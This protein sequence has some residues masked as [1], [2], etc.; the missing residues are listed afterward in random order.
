MAEPILMTALSPTMEDGTIVAWSKNEGDEISAGDVLCEV[1]TDKATMDYESTQDG[2]LLKI[3]LG[4]GSSA[5]V[6]DPIG[7]LG[8]AGEDVADLE[9]ELKAQAK[10]GGD[11][12]GSADS[13]EA[14]GS[15]AKDAP[16]AD[17]SATDTGSAGGDAASSAGS[18]R[19]DAAAQRGGARKAGGPTAGSS[20]LPESD[21]SIKASPLARKLA[22]S[23]NIDLRMIQGSG[24]GGRIVKADIESA[25]PA[26]LTPQAPAG[27]GAAAA[28]GAPVMA[29]REEPVAGKR[30]VIARRLSESKFSAPHYYLK[31]TAEMDSLIAARSMLNRELP[32]KVGFNAF[33][34]KFAAEALKRHPEVN[35]SWQEDSIRYFGSIDIGL[36]VDLGNG[37]ITPIVRNCGAKGVTQ[38]DAELKELIEKARSNSLQPDEYS[39]ATFSISNLGSFGV[40][41]FT[42][43]INPPGAA[44]LALGQTRKT[45][46][47]GEN[48]Q[49][50]VAST[51]TMSLSCDHRVIDGAL[52]GRFIHELTRM[53]ESPV[54]V[55]F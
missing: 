7:I 14:A 13:T 21:R 46:V 4:E 9:K 23:R 42:A 43:I 36:A 38:I 25:N 24:P 17:A 48:D 6:G 11:S 10:S 15:E 39:G 47:V 32:E 12:S 52:A 1:E 51:M 29:D 28:A 37:L 49:I 34:I 5:K 22:A 54:R 8:E 45:P 44:I 3:L 50:R 31:S 53:I 26:H 20:E 55:L 27:G 40:D 2:V 33:M 16:K 18:D 30:K 35:A 41:E 19:G